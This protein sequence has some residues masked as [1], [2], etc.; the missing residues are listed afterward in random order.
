MFRGVVILIDRLTPGRIREAVFG[1]YKVNNVVIEVQHNIFARVGGKRVVTTHTRRLQ[2]A[3]IGSAVDALDNRVIIN[4]YSER[5]S[6]GKIVG[7]PIRKGI[8]G[9]R[10]GGVKCTIVYFGQFVVVSN[11]FRQAR[12]AKQTV[13]HGAAAIYDAIGNE[14]R[15][16]DGAIIEHRMKPT[17]GD[18]GAV[19]HNYRAFNER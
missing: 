6:S 11:T 3:V 12:A 16:F 5:R 14:Q 13:R 2:V 19:F 1:D 15:V 10:K 4:L 9:V 8:R 18:G 17:T 7:F